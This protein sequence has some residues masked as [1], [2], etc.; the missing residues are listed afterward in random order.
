[1][2]SMWK[3][4][5][6]IFRIGKPIMLSII[7]M[8]SDIAVSTYFSIVVSLI[9]A[10]LWAIGVIGLFVACTII[11]SCF[12]TFVGISRSSRFKNLSPAKRLPALLIVAIAIFIAG[13]EFNNWALNQYYQRKSMVVSNPPTASEIAGEVWKKIAPGLNKDVPKTKEKQFFLSIVVAIMGGPHV[14]YKS[15]NDNL[16]YIDFLFLIDLVNKSNNFSKIND[17]YAQLLLGDEWVD[18]QHIPYSDDGQFYWVSNINGIMS[19]AFFQKTLDEQINNTNIEPGKT[20]TG[21]LMFYLKENDRKKYDPKK[22]KALK[23]V[24]LDS[25]RR[26]EEHIII[27]AK[28]LDKKENSANMA[29]FNQLGWKIKEI[30]VDLSKLR[31]MNKY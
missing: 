28:K 25:L 6:T 20:I 31:V 27:M 5:K 19:I 4:I 30:G 22:I 14:A 29:G 26:Q 11:C 1:M 21:I 17:Y 15:I 7:S 9:S 16:Y 23:I 2:S 13:D 18:L 8:L 12:I 10:V 3:T 24:I